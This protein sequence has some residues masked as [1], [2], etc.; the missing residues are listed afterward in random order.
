MPDINQ[1]VAAEATGI[2]TTETALQGELEVL[3]TELATNPQFMAFLD[4]QNQLME[5]QSKASDVWKKLEARMIDAGV[6][7]IKV[8]EGPIVGSIT[9]AERDNFKAVDLDAVP[10]KF[11]KKALDTTKVS[12]YYTLE[13]KL[14]AGIDHTTTKYLTKH[15]NPKKEK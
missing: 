13:G 3:Q 8:T 12:S 9:I 5:V 6:K 15:L 1:E 7:T 2:I 10:R 14:P 11:V 4:K